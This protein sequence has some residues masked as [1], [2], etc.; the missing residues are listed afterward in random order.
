MAWSQHPMKIKTTNVSSGG[1]GGISAN[2]HPQ[3]SPL[4]STLYTVHDRWSSCSC[5]NLLSSLWGAAKMSFNNW[6]IKLRSMIIPCVCVCVCVCM[7]VCT[8]VCL[9]VCVYVCVYVC[10]HCTCVHVCVC[11]HKCV[12]CTCVCVCVSLYVCMGVY[13]CVWSIQSAN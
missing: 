4:Y 3:T 13:V 2:L 9:H 12:H 1:S 10:V 7:C 11:V 8:C 6:R 5:T